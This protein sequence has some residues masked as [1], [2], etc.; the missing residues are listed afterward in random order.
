MLQMALSLAACQ[1]RWFEAT[2]I[3]ID[4]LL[5]GNKVNAFTKFSLQLNR[6]IEIG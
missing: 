2:F 6:M 1:T 4:S 3:F 5:A